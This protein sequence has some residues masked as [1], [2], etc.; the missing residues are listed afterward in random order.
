MRKKK[1]A[2]GGGKP[3]RAGKDMMAAGRFM[4]LLAALFL[5]LSFVVSLVPLQWFEQFYASGTLAI[6]SLFGM[7][8]EVVLQ[9]PVLLKLS[10]FSIPIGFS[11]LCTGILELS[12]VWSAVLASFGIGIR[13]RILGVAAGT[14]GL[15]IFNFL[16]I[17]ASILVIY[18]FG[19]DAGSFSHDVLFR[20]FLF[21]TVA[22]FYYAWF[23]WATGRK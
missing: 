1:R 7:R 21:L 3:G 12:L 8:G 2:A 14:A 5:A 4:L 11:Y 17:V 23:L 9:E 10:V 18:Y 19:L 6:L 16:R 13:E 22:G 20:A 15:V